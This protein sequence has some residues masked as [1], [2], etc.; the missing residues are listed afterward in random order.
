MSFDPAALD[1]MS[2]QQFAVLVG[3]LSDAEIQSTLGAH[4]EVLLEWLFTGVPE[5]FRPERANGGDA[6]IHV[7]ITGG[8]EPDP[9]YAIVVEDGRCTTEKEPSAEPGASL[10]LG[11]SDF[12]RLITG[13][14]NPMTMVM[15]GKLRVRGA[16]PQVMAFQ[17]WFDLPRA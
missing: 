13:T 14:A 1:E 4:R 6:R 7:R 10:M 5:L 12:L 16:L 15:F 17:K 3:S 11:L 9:T 8:E 2:P